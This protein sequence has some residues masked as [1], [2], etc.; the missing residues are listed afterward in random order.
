MPDPRSTKSRKCKICGKP[1]PTHVEHKG[2][3][4]EVSKKV[5]TCG[6]SKCVYS[7]K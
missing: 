2:V 6:R 3:T 4:H 5:R 7:L 1:I